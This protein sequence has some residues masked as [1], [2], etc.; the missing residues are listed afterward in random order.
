MAVYAGLGVPV[1]EAAA[2]R[3]LARVRAFVADRKQPPEEA[4][5]LDFLDAP[6]PARPAPTAGTP[7]EERGPDTSLS[8]VA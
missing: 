2:R 3:V 1:D 6:E 5:L 7:C 4:D 8:T